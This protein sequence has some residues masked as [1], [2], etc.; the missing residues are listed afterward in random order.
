MCI[1]SLHYNISKNHW[2]RNTHTIICWYV[3]TLRDAL[4]RRDQH[5]LNGEVGHSTIHLPWC[6]KTK[7][8]LEWG[9]IYHFSSVCLQE[10]EYKQNKWNSNSLSKYKQL[11]SKLINDRQKFNK[12][13]FISKQNR[14]YK[15]GLK[16][17]KEKCTF[18]SKRFCLLYRVTVTWRPLN[19]VSGQEHP[20]SSSSS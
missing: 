10:N 20:I 6:K 14:G 3:N 5:T 4:G 19:S 2:C 9:F 1:V 17:W 11:H 8:H 7:F 13:L 12:P 16:G 18:V 15:M